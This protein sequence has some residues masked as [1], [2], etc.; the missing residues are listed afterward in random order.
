M[1]LYLFIIILITFASSQEKWSEFSSE[2]SLPGWVKEVFNKK[3][4]NLKYEF[5]FNLN[6]FY[7]R[8]DFNGD[9]KPDIAVLVREK[10]TKKIGIA[11]C[12]YEMNEVVI[13]G[14]GNKYTNQSDDF[15]SKDVWGVNPKGF[16]DPKTKEKY[17]TETVY[18][19]RSET[20]G[21]GLL[22]W[23]GKSYSCSI[24]N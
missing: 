1:K 15:N 11:F 14:A 21:S 13:V 4:L 17:E 16:I 18:F 2:E 7:Q 23:N 20:E 22:F 3:H 10:K 5:Y 12:H 6:P 24:E 8:G 9:G 19:W